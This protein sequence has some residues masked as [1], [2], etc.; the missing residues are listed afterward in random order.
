MNDIWN[1]NRLYNG[2]WISPLFYTFAQNQDTFVYN[3]SISHLYRRVRS[4]RQTK[5]QL[6]PFIS[7]EA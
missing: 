2:M 6:T 4:S 3:N 5:L 7:I 1:H